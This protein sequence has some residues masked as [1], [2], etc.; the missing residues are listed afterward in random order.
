MD[1]APAT[2]R[3]PTGRDEAQRRRLVTT[4]E[5]TGWNISLAA[6][7]LGVARS[8]VYARLERYGLRSEPPR[9]TTASP[10]RPVEGSPV[11]RSDDAPLEW[12]RRS[13]ALLRADLRCSSALDA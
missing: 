7:R 4:L 8:T 13:L 10:L 6:A 9:H 11:P 5:K 12:E 1:G 2:S 3:P